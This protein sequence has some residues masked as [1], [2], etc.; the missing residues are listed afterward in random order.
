ML[1]ACERLYYFEIICLQMYS[2]ILLRFQFFLPHSPQSR[3][4]SHRSGSM[5]L[6]ESRSTALPATGGYRKDIR[7]SSHISEVPEH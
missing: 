5:R 4:Q 3:G 2:E 6:P 1:T 7:S